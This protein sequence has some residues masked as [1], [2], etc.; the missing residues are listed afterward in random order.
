[1]SGPAAPLRALLA[2]GIDYAGLFPPARLSMAD[3]VAR[4]A[5]YLASP[6]RWALGRFVVPGSRLMEFAA[7]AAPHLARSG[8]WRLTVIAGDDLGRTLAEVDGFG[9]AVSPREAVADSLEFRAE[10]RAA[11]RAAMALVPPSLRA[12]AELPLA[13]DPA[14]FVEVLAGSPVA[15]K[16]RTGGV[17]ANAVP[18]AEVVAAWL[19]A[20]VGA[21][22]PFKCTAGLHHPV[23]GEYPLTYEPG[24]A[25]ATMHGYLNV[26]LAAAALLA[27]HPVRVAT[28]LLLE[29]DPSSLVVEEEGVRWRSLFFT[30]K[31]LE[32]LRAAGFVG[33]GSCSFREPLDEVTLLPAS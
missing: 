18:G 17:V 26:M 15:G 20:L 4:F 12:F 19:A 33:F 8:P 2:G 6:D 22:V 7:A 3:A 30:I 5:E 1:M 24:S 23:R 25:V 10:T 11:L 31:E 28:E 9:R 14:P 21:G 29:T 27:G 32:R 13:S 16:L